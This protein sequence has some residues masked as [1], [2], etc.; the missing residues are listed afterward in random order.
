MVSQMTN[1]DLYGV[2]RDDDIEVATPA[3][4]TFPVMNEE[5]RG[6][7]EDI[8]TRYMADNHFTNVTDL[9]DLDKIVCMEL[10][11]WRWQNWLSREKDYWDQPVDPQQM[12]K[13]INEFSKEVRYL[14]KNINMDKSSRDKERSE[15]IATYIH[16]LGVRAKEFGVVRNE[17]AIKAITL[18]KELES[19]LTLYDNCTPEE[20]K[21]HKHLRVQ[22]DDIFNWIRDIAVPEMNQIDAKFRQT[23]QTLW[24]QDV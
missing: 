10:L 6:Y 13:Y 15:S 11:C 22:Q 17:Q 1:Y 14:K 2:T 20:R 24:I 7:F 19:L 8:S 3:G 9:Q 18:F 12:Q 5:E 16:N 23:S 4:A 21:E